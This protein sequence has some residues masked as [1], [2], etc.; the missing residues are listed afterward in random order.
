[1]AIRGRGKESKDLPILLA[2][3]ENNLIKILENLYRSCEHM[4]TEINK[5]NDI[6]RM[7]NSG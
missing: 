6:R 7:I 5:K 1:M 3:G 2:A 4:R